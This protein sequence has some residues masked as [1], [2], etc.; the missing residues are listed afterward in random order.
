MSSSIN[1]ED[2]SCFNVGNNYTSSA[3]SVSVD[4]VETASSV[5]KDAVIEHVDPEDTDE[6]HD[7]DNQ[8]IS[9]FEN[10]TMEFTYWQ[11]VQFKYCL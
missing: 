5:N 6:H 9:F 3:T 4:A 1:H 11:A 10:A 2:P 7:S 8:L